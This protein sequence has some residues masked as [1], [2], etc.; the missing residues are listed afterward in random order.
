MNTKQMQKLLGRVRTVA[1]LLLATQAL[2]ACVTSTPYWDQH[3]G[4]SVTT[5]SQ[6]QIINPDAPAGLPTMT[7][8]DGKTAVS[9]MTSYD[10][11]MVRFFPGGAGTGGGF[12]G[13]GFGA[14]NYGGVGM[15]GGSSR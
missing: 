14:G 7:G 5:L 8:V 15:S 3:F 9:A 13:A 12:G 6:A 1:L 11:S 2:T 4:D 10:R